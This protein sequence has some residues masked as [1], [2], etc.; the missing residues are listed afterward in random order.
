[1]KKILDYEEMLELLEGL[2]P[3]ITRNE[4]VIG[5]SEFGEDI[6][7]YS[8]G[9]GAYHV[10]LTAGTHAS[11]LIS[12]IFLLRFM[13][14]L[15]DEKIKID[16]EFTLHFIPI[17]NPDGTIINTSAI[18][19]IIPRESSEIEGQ[20]ACLQFYL[21]S[22]RDD[23]FALKGNR[24]DK[25]IHR[26]FQ[27]AT[28]ECIDSK[29]KSLKENVERIIK[30][31]NLPKGSLIN[32][33]SNGHGV[34][35][36]ANIECGVYLEKFLRGE[37]EYAHL[38]FNQMDKMKQGPMGCPSREKR[39][40]EESENTAILDYYKRLIEK[41]DVAGSI[42]YH[43]CGGIV[44]YLD[45][46]EEENFWNKDYGEREIEYNREVAKTY[47]EVSGYKLDKP[48]TY[49][50]FCAKLRTLLPGSLVVELGTIR[51]TPLSQFINLKISDLNGL[52]NIRGEL[53]RLNHHFD[54]TC[55]DNEK[56]LVK[57]LGTMASEYKKYKNKN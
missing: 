39:F 9:N 35:L 27:Y 25:I 12:N 28:L 1:M 55:M 21:N 13:K 6:K 23:E 41:Y 43:S 42:I 32:W 47:S 3:E 30:K 53:K 8:Y 57:T 17:V 11:E 2:N 46:M 7:A 45:E 31:N 52:E 56:A 22:V 4:G 14:N 48:K 29:Y 44:Y 40:I 36:N 49:T 20:L 18:R 50:T 34:D 16:E 19:T 33:T 10:I 5:K 24:D 51:S 38:R 15:S 26:M 37:E 54:K